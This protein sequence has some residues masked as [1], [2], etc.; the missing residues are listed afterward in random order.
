MRGAGSGGGGF[1]A[2]WQLEPA[3]PV[4]EDVLQATFRHCRLALN[5]QLGAA[6]APMHLL[7]FGQALADDPVDPRF[8]RPEMR[9]P[10]AVVP[11]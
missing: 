2:H 7:A 3:V 9:S 4:P 6:P 8:D 10:E 1:P 11:P 5:Q